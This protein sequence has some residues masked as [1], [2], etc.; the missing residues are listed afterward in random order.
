MQASPACVDMSSSML[1]TSCRPTSVSQTHLDS[2]QAAEPSVDIQH[3]SKSQQAAAQSDAAH[4]TQLGQ[5]RWEPRRLGKLP[6]RLALASDT[7]KS[8]RK[9]HAPQ[10]ELNVKAEMT[11]RSKTVAVEYVLQCNM[12]CNIDKTAAKST[13]RLTP[14]RWCSSWC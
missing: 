4:H 5:I 11:I 1:H 9:D 10:P 7:K 12:L 2:P 8:L 6:Y 14:G 13:G 3:S